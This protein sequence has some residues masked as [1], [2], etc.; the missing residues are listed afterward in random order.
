MFGNAPGGG[1]CR[2][3]WPSVDGDCSNIGFKGQNGFVLLHQAEAQDLPRFHSRIDE[4]LTLPPNRGQAR[5][6]MRTT[7]RLRG[8]IER[9]SYRVNCN[10]I[11]LTNALA[12]G[13]ED[14]VPLMRIWGKGMREFHATGI[15][16]KTT[17]EYPY[18]TEP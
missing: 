14:F 10:P 5:C 8:E 17:T 3:W 7:Y 1:L 4:G 9:T 11:S 18:E 2:S 6:F 13:G 12:V 15:M 16:S